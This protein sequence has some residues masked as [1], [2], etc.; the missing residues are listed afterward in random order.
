[1]PL[2]VPWKD[3]VMERA[4]SP[5]GKAVADAYSMVKVLSEP[6]QPECMHGSPAQGRTGHTAEPKPPS[7][8]VG[9]WNQPTAVG[10]L[11]SENTP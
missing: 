8:G 3:G 5:R 7:A 6:E 9:G 2:A 1:M 11:T 10:W 4:E